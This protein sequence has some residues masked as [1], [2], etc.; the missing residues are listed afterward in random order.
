MRKLYALK[1]KFHFMVRRSPARPSHLPDWYSSGVLV[2]PFLRRV[3]PLH[4]EGLR[5]SVIGLLR[6]SWWPVSG[7]TPPCYMFPLECQS[8]TGATLWVVCEPPHSMSSVW[9]VVSLLSPEYEETVSP[10]VEVSLQGAEVT[11]STQS[12]ARLVSAHQPMNWRDSIRASDNRHTQRACP[13]HIT[14]W[15]NVK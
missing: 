8:S 15:C 13:L 5:G 1:W 4:P 14:H 7:Q 6:S 11:S 12:T 10:E 2:G 9:S 3:N